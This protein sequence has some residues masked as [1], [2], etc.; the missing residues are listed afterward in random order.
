MARSEVSLHQNLVQSIFGQDDP[1]FTELFGDSSESTEKLE[2]FLSRL[3]HH[4][5][6]LPPTEVDMIYLHYALGKKQL[7]I[8]TIFG[9]TQ[10]AVSY[11]LKRARDRLEYF[12]SVPEIPLS[13]LK[14]LLQPHFNPSD[15]AI[16]VGM[17]ETTCQS[18]VASRL[19]LTQGRV[20]HRFFRAVSHLSK[21]SE[22]YPELKPPYFLFS[23]IAD[24][25]FNLGREV[26][27]P[28]WRDR[29]SP[30]LD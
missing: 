7:D 22:T 9:V 18:I 19:G 23:R 12:L 1:Y 21:L 17:A 24:K 6:R 26:Q 27:L 10:A 11:R 29:A 30:R 20:R 25:G 3:N 15:T 5:S 8:A 2:S 4:I 16:L 28:Q 13:E 14:K